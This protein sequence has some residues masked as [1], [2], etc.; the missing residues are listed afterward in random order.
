MVTLVYSA[1][2]IGTN[3]GRL[4]VKMVEFASMVLLRLIVPV[5][6]DLSVIKLH[7]PVKILLSKK[8]FVCIR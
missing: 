4:H 1:K 3:V 7:V 8:L 2:L 6:L 5:Q